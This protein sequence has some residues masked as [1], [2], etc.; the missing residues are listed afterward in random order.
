[1]R[2]TV[3]YLLVTNVA[4]AAH[5]NLNFDRGQA[6]N[7]M[8]YGDDS[9]FAQL[10]R[11]EDELRSVRVLCCIYSHTYENFIEN[12]TAYSL[13]KNS[14]ASPGEYG[15]KWGAKGELRAR[16]S[17]RAHASGVT[18]AGWTHMLAGVGSR[19]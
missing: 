11:R 6:T 2:A 9:T 5:T 4:T 3:N 7:D 10:R 15:A 8:L 18:C 16:A 17:K 14:V 12:R 13:S 1:M 19:R